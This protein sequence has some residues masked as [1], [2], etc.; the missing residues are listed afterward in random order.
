MCKQILV[1]AVKMFY[2]KLVP[3]PFQFA[4]YRAAGR[5]QFRTQRP[6]RKVKSMAL[7]HAS[8]AG[9]AHAKRSVHHASLP[10]LTEGTTRE[11]A[12]QSIA[13]TCMALHQ[14]RMRWGSR[15]PVTLELLAPCDYNVTIRCSCQERVAASA[16][17]SA[18]MPSC[19]VVLTGP[20]L[21]NASK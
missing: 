19:K 20:P 16:S 9:N 11:A 6:V 8:D 3:R 13:S 1:I 21:A 14:T 2:A 15:I 5:D 12:P 18:L 10:G 17:S 4:G 7:S